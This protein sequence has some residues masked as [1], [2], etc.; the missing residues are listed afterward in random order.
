M[1]VTWQGWVR[2]SALEKGL[3]SPILSRQENIFMTRENGSIH[4]LILG[5]DWSSSGH[6]KHG[7]WRRATW[8]AVFS[9]AGSC[10]ECCIPEFR[11]LCLQG[12]SQAPW[13]EWG[14]KVVELRDAVKSVS[15]LPFHELRKCLAIKCYTKLHAG[16]LKPLDFCSNH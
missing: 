4:C 13:Q 14:R 9:I 16:G 15:F 3:H 6:P 10:T 11:N 7:T 2:Y 8:C 12:M 1:F 5:N